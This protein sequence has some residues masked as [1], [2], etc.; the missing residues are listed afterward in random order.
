[1]LSISWRPGAGPP[2]ELLS[3]LL[4]V[5]QWVPATLPQPINEN[6]PLPLYDQPSIC[7][8]FTGPE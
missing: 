2:Q 1:M 6:G 7:R 5:L 8:S 3:A 4:F